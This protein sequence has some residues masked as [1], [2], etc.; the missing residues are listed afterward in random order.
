MESS[1]SGSLHSLRELN[2]RRVVDALR[3]RGTA[4]RAEIARVT[5]LSRSTVSSIVADLMASG[6]VSEQEVM[7]VAHGDQGGRPPVPLSLNKSAGVAVGVDFGHTHLRVAAADLSHDILAEA[8]HELDVDHSAADGLDA[9]AKLVGEVL[10]EAGVDR[11]R[12]IGVG[13]GLPGPINHLTGA[14]G[15]SAI[16]PGWVGIDAAAEMSRRLGLAVQVENDANLGALAE[17]VWGSGQGHAELIYIKLSSGVGAGLLLGGRLYRGAGG[18]AGEIGH[19]PAQES[20][21]ICRC[22]MRGC[23]ETVASA[24]AIAELLGRSRGEPVST[25]RLLELAGDGD[26]A[27]GKLIGEAGREIGITIASLCNL[28][29]PS[30]VIVGGDLSAAGETITE[31][32]GETIRRYSIPSAAD[33]VRVVSGVLGERA[34]LLGALALVLHSSDR[35]VSRPAAG[36]AA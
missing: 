17:F 19:T 35:F 11:D 24:R 12:V 31:P 26:A 34:E 33:E 7:G 4:S 10:A 28:I 30:L 23:L 20:G 32:I 5:G 27:A 9:A 18:T 36:V 15:S 21:A 16:L 8:G 3:D 14:V 25:P 1:D 2:R 6:L 29:N 22:G 13:M